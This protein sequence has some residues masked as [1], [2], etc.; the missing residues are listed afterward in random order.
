MSIFHFY[1]LI[2]SHFDKILKCQW[3]KIDL[4]LQ[5]AKEHSVKL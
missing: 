3:S 4:N 1:T 5:E 2:K